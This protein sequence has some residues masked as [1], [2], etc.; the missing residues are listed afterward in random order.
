METPRSEFASRA[1]QCGSDPAPVQAIG[2]EAVLCSPDE[3]KS[4]K[5]AAQLVGRVRNRIFIVLLSTTDS[6]TA[7]SVL[8]EKART[9]GEQ[10]AG[11]LF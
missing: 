8:R 4:G 11:N 7:L 9:V 3:G 2:N 5:R 1:G 6:S 10:V